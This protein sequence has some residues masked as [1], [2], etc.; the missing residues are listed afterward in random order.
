MKYR[1]YTVTI[2]TWQGSEDLIFTATNAN[3]AIKK[4]RK[5]MFDNGHFSRIDGAPKYKA[6][7]VRYEGGR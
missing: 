2:T 4:A 5:F 6:K 7:V 3:D 1:D